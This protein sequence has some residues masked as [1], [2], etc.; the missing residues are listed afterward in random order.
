MLG[1]LTCVTL[2]DV[3][4]NIRPHAF[5]NKVAFEAV[6]GGIDPGMTPKSTGVASSYQFGLEGRIVTNPE[7]IMEL[8]QTLLETVSIGIRTLDRQL[9]D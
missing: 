4:L 7:K 6:I 9:C 5:P 2:L 1:T 8:D 3:R